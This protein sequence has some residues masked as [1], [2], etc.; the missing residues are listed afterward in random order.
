MNYTVEETATKLNVSK[1]AIYMKLK[2]PMF[3]N[4][5]SKKHGKTYIDEN[6]LNLIKDSLK[7]NNNSFKKKVEIQDIEFDKTVETPTVTSNLVNINEV[8]IDTDYINY[9]KADIVYLKDQLNEQ[10][11][12][13]DL[14]ISNLNERLKQEQELNKN[15]QILQLRQ[16]QDIKL[17]EDHVQE[18]G[19]K[20]EEVKENMIHREEH[21]KHKSLFSKIF[22][23]ND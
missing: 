2:S 11:I 20:L 12:S 23:S 18:F 21:Q 3:R 9:L 13:K 7:I 10:S 6:L 22:K 15:S 17:L 16:P 19:T 4:Q 14:Q 8:A 1:Q 5:I